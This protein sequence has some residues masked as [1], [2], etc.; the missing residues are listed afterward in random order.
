M[1]KIA[2]KA[3][4]LERKITP[5]FGVKIDSTLEKEV[6]NRTWKIAFNRPGVTAA[7]K[8]KSAVFVVT[9][10]P[11]IAT[12]T[13][14]DPEFAQ[15]LNSADLSLPDGIGIVAA[16]RFLSQP[17]PKNKILRF[18]VLLLQGLEVGLALLFDHD[19]LTEDMEAIPGRKFFEELVRK[20]AQEGKRIFLLGGQPGVAEK[21][22][23][24]IVSSFQLPISSCRWNSGP[25]LTERGGPATSKDRV[26]EKE[27][28]GEINQFRPDLLFVGFGAPKQERWLAKNLPTLRVKLAMA[29]GGTFDYLARRVPTPPQWLA[30][31]G[32]EWLWRLVTQPSRA[33]RIFTAVIRFPWEVFKWKLTH[34]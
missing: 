1:K 26:L 33:P 13:L 5:I 15:I 34:N 30:N 14:K 8:Q 22:A 3:S 6:L 23:G 2:K 19:W 25:W 16:A 7:K 31:A 29:V 27:V 32:F 21:A 28:I 11:E 4:L 24:K 20:A 9:P 18:P 10:N 17:A 12:I